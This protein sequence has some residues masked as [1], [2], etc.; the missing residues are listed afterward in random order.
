MATE[1]RVMLGRHQ[2][3][4]AQIEVNTEIVEI[5]RETIGGREILVIVNGTD[6]KIDIV[7][8]DRN[9]AD[10]KKTETE[11]GTKMITIVDIQM[12]IGTNT[13]LGTVDR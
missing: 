5:M 4:V 8:K 6:V 12:K 10:M 13:T 11:T 9:V 7:S 1:K 2:I 3:D